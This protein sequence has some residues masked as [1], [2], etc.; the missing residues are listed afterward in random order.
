MAAQDTGW[1]N[2]KK[3]ARR[4]FSGFASKTTR[5]WPCTTATTAKQAR[6]TGI[7]DGSYGQMS[8]CGVLVVLLSSVGAPGGATAT[9]EKIELRCTPNPIEAF[10]GSAPC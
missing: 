9:Q 1:K 10:I 8:L 5:I 7:G 4:R 2:K 3:F 6:S